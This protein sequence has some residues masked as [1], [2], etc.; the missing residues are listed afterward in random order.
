M[1]DPYVVP[2]GV[3]VMVTR[4]S[5]AQIADAERKLARRNLKLER[6][7]KGSFSYT[8]VSSQETHQAFASKVDLGRAPP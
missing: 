4:M 1:F 7:P 8:I 2:L 3:T 5:K 6:S